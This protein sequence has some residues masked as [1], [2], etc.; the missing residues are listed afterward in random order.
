MQAQVLNLLNDLKREFGITYLFITHDLS[1]ARFMS[2]RLLVMNQGQIV[3]S[4]PAAEVYANPQHP[5]TPKALLAAI[6]KDEPGRHS[7]PP[8]PAART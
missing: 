1:V 3:E 2:D 6:P 8:W 4:G 7:R 5:N